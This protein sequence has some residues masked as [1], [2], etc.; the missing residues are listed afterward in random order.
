MTM[1]D[2]VQLTPPERELWLEGYTWGLI[3]GHD[4]G[5]TDCDEDLARLQRAAARIVHSHA[6]PPRTRKPHTRH[7]PVPWPDETA[8]IQPHALEVHLTPAET[9]WKTATQ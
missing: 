2:L 1:T 4:Q 3:H 7:A 5:W 6:Q 8:P 9:A